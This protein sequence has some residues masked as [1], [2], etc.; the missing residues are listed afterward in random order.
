MEQWRIHRCTWFQEVNRLLDVDTYLNC[1]F[2]AGARVRAAQEIVEACQNGDECT[3]GFATLQSAQ[4][5]LQRV[6]HWSENLRRDLVADSVAAPDDHGARWLLFQSPELNR[7]EENGQI[8]CYLCRKCRAALAHRDAKTGQPSPHMP[9]YARANG[10]W[11]GPDPPEI[12]E[13]SYAE[14]KVINLARVY[15]SV[16]RVFLDARSYARTGKSDAPRYHQKNVVA[17]PQDPDAAL[18]AVGMSPRSLTKMLVVQFVGGDRQSLRYHRDLSVSVVKLR[19][20]FRWLSVNSWPFMEATKHHA[21]W[22]TG[23]LNASLEELLQQYT[24][25]VGSSD[26]GV[27]AE[28]LAAASMIP[29]EHASVHAAGPADCVE[30]KD[31]DEEDAGSEGGRDEEDNG[32]DCAAAIHGGVDDMAPVQIWDNVMR[33]GCA[34]L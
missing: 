8:T 30:T 19:R 2:L 34:E 26:G 25:S 4:S 29:R 18:R 28:V 6:L 10:L 3:E 33:Q 27:P 20:A 17:Y 5:W 11:R 7:N 14:A 21:L 24:D 31:E 23:L 22:N 16:K 15:V 13:L 1:I 32:A 9:E 12:C